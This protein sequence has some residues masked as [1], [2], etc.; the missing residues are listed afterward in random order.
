MRS[1][2]AAPGSASRAGACL[3]EGGAPVRHRAQHFRPELDSHR[4]I[5]PGLNRRLGRGDEDVA[6]AAHRS[7][8]ARPEPGARELRRGRRFAH[9]VDGRRIFFRVHLSRI[10][11]P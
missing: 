2:P 11:S 1:G 9:C 10:V 8:L 4:P 6:G 7:A 3:R 5:R